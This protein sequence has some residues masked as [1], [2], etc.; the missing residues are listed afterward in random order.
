MDTLEANVALGFGADEREYGLAAAMLRALG[1]RSIALMTNSPD[2]VAKLEAE[3]M[4]VHSRIP[5]VIPPNAHNSAY[6]ATKAH[7]MGHW[8]DVPSDPAPPE[9]FIP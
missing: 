8:L 7:R 6:L 5:H 3:G 1:V 4:P 9:V 2:K